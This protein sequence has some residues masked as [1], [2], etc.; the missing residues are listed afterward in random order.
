MNIRPSAMPGDG[1]EITHISS[2]SLEDK[3]PPLVPKC[4]GSFACAVEV[5]RSSPDHLP[6]D[7]K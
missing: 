2:L 3:T 1:D 7:E 5:G 4:A 6:V